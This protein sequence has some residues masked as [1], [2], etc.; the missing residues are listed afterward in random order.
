MKETVGAWRPGGSGLRAPP[1]KCLP[2]VDFESQLA[3]G[4]GLK[5]GR[6]ARGRTLVPAVRAGTPCGLA[7]PHTENPMADDAKKLNSILD[8]LTSPGQLKK[9]V[10]GSQDQAKAAL[11]KAK[12]KPTGYKD[13]KAMAEDLGPEHDIP[14]ALVLALMSRET[15]FGMSA[16]LD[17]D[18]WGDGGNAFGVLQ[19]DKGS[20]KPVGTDDIFSKEHVN[21]AL[22]IFEKKRAEVKKAHKDWSEEEIL[23]GTIC[24][25]NAGTKNIKTSPKKD[26]RAL[27]DNGKIKDYSADVW[28]QA[29][30]YKDTLWPK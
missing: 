22:G 10:K 28:A 23:A 16:A 6:V 15:E 1:R 24:A 29:A 3:R 5:G 19:V 14:P 17:K 25:Y 13:F 11:L 26:W 7:H 12:K 9:G 18:G 4:C 8:K 21:Q 2:D 20:E 27:D 30:Y